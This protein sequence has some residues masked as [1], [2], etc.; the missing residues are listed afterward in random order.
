MALGVLRAGIPRGISW[1]FRPR[2]YEWHSFRSLGGKLLGYLPEDKGWCRHN[3][4]G[5]RNRISKL[6][7]KLPH[8]KSK[9]SR[10]FVVLMMGICRPYEDRPLQGVLVGDRKKAAG[11]GAE[12]GRVWSRPKRAGIKASAT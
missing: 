6:A 8:K 11:E 3:T 5:P 1:C 12:E 10:T 9:R 7:G 2:H 4:S